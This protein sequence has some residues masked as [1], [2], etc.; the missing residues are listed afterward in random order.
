MLLRILETS[1]VHGHLLASKNSG[2]VRQAALIKRLKKQASVDEQII[3]IENGDFIQ[4]SPLAYF[5]NEEI[6]QP[7]V[8]EK[9]LDSVGYDVSLLGNHEFNYGKEFLEESLATR[10]TPILCAN[11]LGEDAQP[12]FGQPYK[13]LKCGQYYV[14]ILALTTQ[15]IP[16]WEPAQHLT[17]LKFISA[18]EAA[19]KY[20]PFLRQKADFVLIAYH[21]GL[22]RDL[23]TDQP[24]EPL[25]GENEG[26]AL[27]KLPGVT[28]LI[29][30]HQHRQIAGH[31]KGVPVIQPGCFGKLVGEIK[32]EI[33]AGQVVKSAAKLL[34]V[35]N[36]IPDPVLD[37][38][39]TQ[40]KPSMDA[41]LNQPVCQFKTPQFEI[42]DHFQ[43]RLKGHPYIDL[44]N[45][46]QAAASGVDISAAAIFDDQQ[47]GFAKK[48]T[49]SQIQANYPFSNGLAILQ[50]TGAD[51]KAALEQC[52]SYWK[53]EDGQIVV[54]P[55]YLFP[56]IQ[57]FNYDLYRGIDYTI[58]VSQPI[59]QR[60][61]R[62]NYHGQP[63]Q[64]NDQLKIVLNQY[65]AL[66]GGDFKMFSAAKIIKE[67]PTEMSELIISY[68][69]GKSYLEIKK[70]GHYQVIK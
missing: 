39:L 68:L 14:A 36:E 18:V 49:I 52:A 35:E 31:L 15:Y 27:A 43:A 17:G 64:K 16:H 38:Q 4:G 25:T 21:G 69:K 62:L 56:K 51:L 57:H 8:L 46:I 6:K 29:T 1:D 30:G 47:P 40:L 9:A 26:S 61:I 13:I 60:V 70:A 50:I 37:Q 20:L 63:V 33:Q 53:I 67:I 34:A 55:A 3:T 32:L 58:K 24:T 42:H 54:N 41:W 28:A 45:Q 11:I 19:K 48:V 10:Q 66:G 12:Y 23:A 2:L 44:V 5:V 59:G 7:S 22:E 65:R